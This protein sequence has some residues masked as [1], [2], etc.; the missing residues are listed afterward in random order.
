MSFLAPSGF[1]SGFGVPQGQHAKPGKT[2][3][4]LTL[5]FILFI[6]IVNGPVLPGLP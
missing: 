1:F 2:S 6:M 4:C 5:P 3:S